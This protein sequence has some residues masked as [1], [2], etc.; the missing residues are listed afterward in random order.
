MT[1]TPSA[2]SPVMQYAMVLLLAVVMFVIDMYLCY[3]CVTTTAGTCT[4][5]WGSYVILA[6]FA[7]IAL[8]S[9]YR[10]CSLRRAETKQP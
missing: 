5:E 1:I 9:G 4:L 7:A 10:L 3:E 8:F 6:I 2:P